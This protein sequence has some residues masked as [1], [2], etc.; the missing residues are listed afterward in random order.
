MNG[1]TSGCQDKEGVKGTKRQRA[2][3]SPEHLQNQHN[4]TATQEEPKDEKGGRLLLLRE[5]RIV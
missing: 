1:W 3:I 2:A 5:E 4:T